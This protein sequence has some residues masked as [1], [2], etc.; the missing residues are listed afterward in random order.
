MDEQ[1]MIEQAE[2]EREA[3]AEKDPGSLVADMIHCIAGDLERIRIRDGETFNSR[4]E[5]YSVLLKA[6]DDKTAVEKDLKSAVKDL[7]D[8]VKL[9]DDNTVSAYLKNIERVARDSAMAWV[10]VAAICQKAEASL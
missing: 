9:E 5:S 3:E 1:N 6:L 8:G 2:A 10:R 7:W 4:Y